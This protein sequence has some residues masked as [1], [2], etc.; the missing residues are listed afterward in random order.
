MARPGVDRPREGFSPSSMRVMWLQAAAAVVLLPLITWLLVVR[1]RTA[2]ETGETVVVVSLV[3]GLVAAALGVGVLVWIVVRSNRHRREFWRL[4]G[5]HSDG[6]TF[7]VTRSS[8][9]GDGS[10]AGRSRRWMN[11]RFDALRISPSSIQL[12]RVGP[13]VETVAQFSTVGATVELATMP[14]GRL[15]M[16][17]LLF[18]VEDGRVDITAAPDRTDRYSDPPFDDLEQMVAT[19]RELLNNQTPG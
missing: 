14:V 1:L 2:I 9:D 5:S 18:I 11:V 13:T 16:R 4:V 8:F 19:I 6:V 10:T 17:A 7:R 3:I 15:E 12:L